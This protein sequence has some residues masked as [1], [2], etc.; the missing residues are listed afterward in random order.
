MIVHILGKKKDEYSE[1][2]N[3]D[4]DDAK[5]KPLQMRQNGVSRQMRWFAS[6][7]GAKRKPSATKR[8]RERK[9]EEE[10]GR[11]IDSERERER[12]GRR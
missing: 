12:E 5:W 9:R 4:P 7:S 2:R 1:V 8:E 6:A 3:L 11:Q 10:R